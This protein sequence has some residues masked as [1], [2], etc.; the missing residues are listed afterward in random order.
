MRDS[1]RRFGG[2]CPALYHRHREE[3]PR[4]Y[5]RHSDGARAGARQWADSLT[6]CA[7][8]FQHSRRPRYA[9]QRIATPA[10]LP[11]HPPP[12]AGA[13]R[14]KLVGGAYVSGTIAVDAGLIVLTGKGGGDVLVNPDHVVAIDKL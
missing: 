10:A 2:A 13:V 1:W 14:V 5:G 9:R 4:E 11:G 8:G 7:H 6:D 12:V 3:W